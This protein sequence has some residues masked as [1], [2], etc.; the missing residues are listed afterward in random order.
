MKLLLH[1]CCAPC[2]GAILEWLSANDIRPTI[3][4]GNSNIFPQKEYELRE[5]ECDRYARTLGLEIVEDEYNHGKWLREVGA[6]REKEPERGERCLECFKFRLRRAAKYAHEHGYDTLATSLASSRWKN[7]EQVNAAGEEA[8]AEYNDVKWWSRNWRK[9]GLQQRRGEIIKE[10]NFYNQL[11]CGCEFSK[12]SAEEYR[13]AK[14]Q[15]G[16]GDRT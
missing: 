4:Y 13:A 9:E 1:S 15:D 14:E 6:G 5:S 16:A 10:Q 7:L 11:Y 8:C 12:R 2:S 3:F